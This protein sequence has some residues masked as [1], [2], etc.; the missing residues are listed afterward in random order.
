MTRYRLTP[1]AQR[2]FKDILDYVE[3]EFGLRIAEEV[4]DRLQA[5]L[6]SLGANPGRG[7]VRQDITGDER[8]RFLSVGPSLI[9]YRL[10]EDVVEILFVERG[11]RDWRGLFGEQT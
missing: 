5:A 6:E 1:R 11:E 8:V 4:L 7:R 10:A 3:R 2:G 9:A